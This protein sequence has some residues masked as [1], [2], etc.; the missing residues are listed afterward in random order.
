MAT[1]EN[2]IITLLF[3]QL[4]HLEESLKLEKIVYKKSHDRA[5]F[6]FQSDVLVGEKDYLTI[7]KFLQKQYPQMNIALR[8][9]S[10]SLGEDFL[11]NIGN[12]HFVLSDF[13]VRTF[14]SSKAWVKSIDWEVRS[15]Q[16]VLTFPDA[17]SMN[18]MKDNQ[19][20]DKLVKA[21]WNI[22]RLRVPVELRVQGNQE[23]R[24][25]ALKAEREKM[26]LKEQEQLCA[27]SPP[28]KGQQQAK[29]GQSSTKKGRRNEHV[30]C[31][32]GIADAPVPIVELHQD[33]GLVA[34]EG[35]I[36]DVEKR[37]L[38]GGELLLVTFAVT[39]YT[40][41]IGCKLFLRY[42][43]HPFG[44]KA[45]DL[46][47]SPITRQE[48][49]QVDKIADRIALGQFVKVRG[50]C[51]YDSFAREPVI[52]VRDMIQAPKVERMDHA[53]EKR[54][55]L[56]MHTHMSAMDALTSPEKLIARAAKWGHCAVAITDHGVLQ[57]FPAAFSAAK[58]HD[59]K[60]LPGVEAYLTEE[61]TIVENCKAMSL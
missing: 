59:I 39:D 18:F 32:R 48:K 12:Y 21:I 55:E 22:F 29:N 8:I 30:I 6:L 26:L 19:V 56:H 7:R 3:S 4:P 53:P 23:A 2:T 43:K 31:G 1:N 38:K 42:R 50:E 20:A 11:A 5:Y 60:L 58:K 45:E 13:L 10:P 34:I 28:D 41:T 17:F 15:G 40:S 25:A 36:V 24:I 33:A 27:C 35:E 54:V 61:N 49:E 44:K 47:Q 52:N 57:A 16:V 14:P 9:T 46:D 51:V 37:E